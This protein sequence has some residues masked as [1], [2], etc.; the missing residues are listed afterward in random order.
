MKPEFLSDIPITDAGSLAEAIDDLMPR[1]AHRLPLWRGHAVFD[2]P[3]RAE[4]FRP[5]PYGSP[6]DE[7]SLIRMFMAQAVSRSRRCPDL[8]D[9]VGWLMLARHYGLPTRLLDWSASPLV[10]LF[11]VLDRQYQGTD[12]CLWALSP[13][14][15]NLPVVG[16]PRLLAEDEPHVQEMVDLAFA[17]GTATRPVKALAIGTREIAARVLAQQGAFT[18][19]ADQTDLADADYGGVAVVRAFRIPAADKGRLNQ[20][21]QRLSVTRSSLFPDL[22]SLAEDLKSRMIV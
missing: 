8:V 9:R 4:V 22:G 18:I 13:G 11:F 21:L 16:V 2:W 3:L 7:V 1:F 12:G 15:L 14:E 20:L 6:Y 5:G 19:H 17:K 10:A